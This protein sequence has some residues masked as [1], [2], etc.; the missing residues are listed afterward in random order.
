MTPVTIGLGCD[1]GAAL[2]TLEAALTEAT[3]GLGE[4]AVR[5]IATI[6]RKGDELAILELCAR[7]GWPLRLYPAEA[8]A[9]VAVPHPSATVMRV[10]GT[11]AVAEAAALLAAGVEMNDLLVEK[12][13]YRGTD[14]KNATVSIARWRQADD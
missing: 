11:P 9:Q 14:G 4:I 7:R 12:Y 10:M 6:D 1:R 8:L 13:R 2:A 5:A 3:R